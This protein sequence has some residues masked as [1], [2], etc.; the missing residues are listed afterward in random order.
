VIPYVP[1]PT[2]ELSGTTLH[3]FRVL[4]LLAIAVQL[5]LT[6]RRAPR[7]GIPRET[8][9]ALI[10]WGV[11]VG[12]VSAHVFDVIAYRPEVLRTD[13]LEL[14]R[15]WGDLASTGG[16]LGGIAALFLVAR[17]RGLS[18]AQLASFF[19]VVMFALPFTLAI[20]R[21]GCALQHDHL[22]VASTSWLAVN[23]PPG[24]PWHGP[25]FDLGLLEMLLCAAIA[26]LFVLLERVR[27]RSLQ[28][29]GSTFALFFALY[30]PGRFALDFLRVGEARY[31]ELTPAQWLMAG[32]ALAAGAWLARRPRSA[33][34]AS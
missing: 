13:P 23:F 3:A 18:G 28:P 14:L 2:I 26:G 1:H 11:V 16:M 10:V 32:A 24:A 22:G 8:A 21:L 20:G 30:G 5:E 34:S 19:D 33:E 9:G 31:A 7:N 15:V 29:P 12:L 4:A 27:P 6:V 17:R 25:R